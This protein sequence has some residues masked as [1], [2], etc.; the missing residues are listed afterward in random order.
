MVRTLFAVAFLITIDQSIAVLETDPSLV[1][2]ATDE[3]IP[4]IEESVL[5][6]LT[7]ESLESLSDDEST[8]IYAARMFTPGFGIRWVP[9]V[10][11]DILSRPGAPAIF[12]RLLKNSP[13]RDIRPSIWRWCSDHPAFSATPQIMSD[14]I[15]QYRENGE[16]WGRDSRVGFAYLLASAGGEEVSAIIEELAEKGGIFENRA[17]D[18][19]LT[20][21]KAAIDG[22]S[23]PATKPEML[24]LTAQPPA[25]INPRGLH[26]SVARVKPTLPKQW[27]VCTGTLAAAIVFLWGMWKR[28]AKAAA[29]VRNEK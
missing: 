16:S 8:P 26:P 7:K 12:F 10:D 21:M 5:N 14:A 20:R 25:T 4:Y 6:E 17:K 28:G 27:L 15:A 1:T 23:I 22:S 11:A 18:R 24:P 13:R 9:L 29:N 3:A 19:Y 2:V